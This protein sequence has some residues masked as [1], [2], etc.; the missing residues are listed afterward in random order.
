M[1]IKV[2]IPF[3]L[4]NLAS[5]AGEIDLEVEEPVTIARA[6]DALEKRYPVLRGTVRDHES[7]RR[8]PFI[9]FFAGEEDM[10]L[11]PADT[12]LPSAVQKGKEPLLIVG[13]MA[14]G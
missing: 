4:R 10:S 11:C 8:R 2:V 13:A 14:G 1:M 6:V 9:R 5:V 12:E 3:H 7:H